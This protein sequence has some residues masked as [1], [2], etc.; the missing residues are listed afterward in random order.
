MITSICPRNSSKSRTSFTFPS[1]ADSAEKNGSYPTTVI[2]IA[3]A[4]VAT[5]RPIR[6][7]PTTP[8]V[9]PASC[10]PW[11]WFRFQL[12]AFTWALAAG[13]LRAR[14]IISASAC[15]AVDSVDASAVFMTS[16]PLAVAAARSMLSTPTPARAIARIRPGFSSTFDTAGFFTPDRTIIASY[17]PAIAA[18]SS[19]PNPTFTSNG[20]PAPRRYSNPS[21]ANSS[22]TRI[23]NGIAAT[24]SRLKSKGCRTPDGRSQR[25]RAHKAGDDAGGGTADNIR[26]SVSGNRLGSR[27]TRAPGIA[28]NHIERRLW[29]RRATPG[30]CPECGTTAV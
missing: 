19:A 15:S 16:T 24:L 10:V 20:T 21:S 13:I 23:F 14:L 8:S 26:G 18:S 5:V 27:R 28:D 12:P 29:V 6:P 4:R 30:R 22:A 25:R 1:R 3:S 2:S 9:L 17:S 11:Y 7:S